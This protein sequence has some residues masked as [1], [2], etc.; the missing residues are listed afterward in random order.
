MLL[1]TGIV[2]LGAVS[3]L[4]QTT[5]VVN[6]GASI[7]EAINNATAGDT[8]QLVA[9]TYNENVQITKL[10]T[11]NG[12]G[13]T[14]II[15]PPL[16]T[17]GSLGVASIRIMLAG[18]GTSET[19]RTVI[20]NL[21]VTGG[22]NGVDTE[23]FPDSISRT[24]TFSHITLENLQVDNNIIHG[25]DAYTGSGINFRKWS[26]YN[27]I[28]MNNIIATDNAKF[29]IDFN[30]QINSLEGLTVN[31]GYFA[32]NNIAGLEITTV[33]ANNIIIRD[34]TFENNG[35]GG[36]DVEGDIVLSGPNGN[37]AITD[38]TINSG[39]ASTGIRLSGPS[40]F[41]PAGTI[42]LTDV[43]ITGTQL[44]WS[45]KDTDG[46]NPYPSGAIVISRYSD[47]S[48]VSFDNVNLN[49]TA[50]VGL[51]LGT[52]YNTPSAPTLDLT[53][54]SFNGTYEQLITLGRHGNNPS[55]AKA[56]VNV[57]AGDATF[58]GLTDNFAIE[59]LFHH[60]LDDSTLGLVVWIPNN[61][62]VTPSSGS[63]QRGV[64]AVGDNWTVN[65]APGTYAGNIIVYKEG[66]TLKSTAGPAATILDASFVDKSGYVNESGNS[67]NYSWAETDDPGLLRNGFLIW[68]DDVTI[69]GFTVL[70]ASYPT[71]YNRGIAVLI[72][73]ISTTY[74]GFVPWNLDEWH[75]LIPVVDQP[76]PSGV[77][78][79]NMLIVGPSDGVYIW[80]S[81]DN[82]IEQNI[83]INTNPLGGSGII[84]Y[85]G[86]TGNVIRNNYIAN[87]ADA[88]AICGVWPNGFLDV[89][90]TR[91]ESNDLVYSVN[92]LKFYNVADPYDRGVL[93][94]L[95]VIQG[96]TIGVL[97]EG[98]HASVPEV[99]YNSIVGNT[100]YGALNMDGSADLDATL[101]WWG[102]NDGPSG[103]GTGAGDSVSTNVIFSPWLGID[104]DGDAGT[105]GVQITGPVL[106][107]VDDIGP[108]PT[109][110]YLN[111]AIAGANSTELPYRDTIEVRHGTYNASE[112]ITQAVKL[113]SQ[114]GSALHT[115]LNGNV[116]INGNGVLVG[117]PLQGFRM[118]GNVTVGAGKDAG[119]SSI[120]WC[121]LYGNVTNNGTGTFDAQYNYWGTQL[122]S[123]IDGRTTGLIDY[124]PFL[125]KNADD[126]YVDATAIISAGLASGIDPAID[127]LWLMVQLG[128]DVNTF[129][130]YAG[131]AGAGAF[132]GAPAGAEIILSGAAGGGGAVEGTI[133]GTYAPG[134][135]IDGRFT[136]TDPVTGE[137][138]TDAAVTTSLLGPDGA[139]VSWGC[140][141]YDETTG[142]YVFSIDTSGLSPGTY[143]LII[144]TDDGQSKTVSIEVLGA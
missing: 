101:N 39:G 26:N 140:A 38:V 84:V 3:G 70:N 138:V 73:S 121:D 102:D 62:Y 36:Y 42:T 23:N 32:N 20:S 33:N 49:S 2:L 16:S 83:I 60:A 17:V 135:P 106:I 68:S 24:L 18:C 111:A 10:L 63:I 93:G 64:D 142:E 88:V 95:N 30:A 51:F 100:V 31:G 55:Y 11:L 139:L 61:V 6:P 72:G 47:V 15:Q 78:V 96:N 46:Y 86:G 131:V 108:E 134:E 87:A 112:P 128:Q 119:T 123:V 126:S 104:P 132:A 99:H 113:V 117:L 53:G 57:D 66:V 92:G 74:A 77:T 54:I 118:N 125:P 43:T 22:Y 80:S 127:Q 136:L 14:T 52:I 67:I 45:R 120:N 1:V 48:N 82:T 133:S 21:R 97:V 34:A 59:D 28:I 71:D 85:E 141:T 98:G 90:G 75:G 105:V 81:S 65:V 35:L 19:D 130:G 143:E 4:A 41:A 89:G 76:T 107:I 13:P 37:I 116:S 58:V 137:P 79:R 94:L 25:V 50:P 124:D 110:G 114:P 109:G 69:D 7:Q 8:I 40:P 27:D 122:A 29:G 56:N 103:E 44:Q 144:Q 129:I 115:T 12:A 91:V 9:G 5:W